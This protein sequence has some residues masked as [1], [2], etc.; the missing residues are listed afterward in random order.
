[1]T[2]ATRLAPALAALLVSA[3]SGPGGGR[4]A[5]LVGSVGDLPLVENDWTA[6]E[7]GLEVGVFTGPGG[8][9]GD[10]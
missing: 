9:S 8:A 4:G 10:G 2:L 7:P 3:P 1:V 5:S 6:V